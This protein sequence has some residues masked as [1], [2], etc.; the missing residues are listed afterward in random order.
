MR[1]RRQVGP[2]EF[3]EP[4]PESPVQVIEVIRVKADV[5]NLVLA[6]LSHLEPHCSPVFL[7]DLRQ[8]P[9]LHIDVVIWKVEVRVGKCPLKD[10]RV[11]LGAPL[12]EVADSVLGEVISNPLL[13]PAPDVL[14][15]HRF[16]RG[17]VLLPL[18]A[19]EVPREIPE[20]T[21]AHKSRTGAFNKDRPGVYDSPGVEG[22]GE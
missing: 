10:Q 13:G 20:Q 12:V 2:D 11:G 1:F 19:G 22:S 17:A 14:T 4:G 16:G 6:I 7:A 5:P 21:H 9:E 15:M 8:P 3:P 18:V